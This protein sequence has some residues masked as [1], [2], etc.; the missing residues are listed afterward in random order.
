MSDYE[1][2]KLSTGAT[3]RVRG[4]PPLMT[5]DV[6]ARNPDLKEPRIPLVDVEGVAGTEVM[7]ARPGE[8]V[9]EKWMQARQDVEEACERMQTDFMWYWGVVSWKL[10]EM[11][12][13]TAHVPRG[14]KFPQEL[15][16]FGLQPREG[17]KGKRV[18]FIR[19]SLFVTPG[20]VEK[21]RNIMFNMGSLMAEEVDAAVDSFPVAEVSEASTESTVQ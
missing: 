8:E 4:V 20:D 15:K 19:H 17:A 13:F 2:I 12:R 11:D 21:A 5:I 14:W 18:D 9:Y 10:P 3:V 6:I 7:P 16:E 1:E